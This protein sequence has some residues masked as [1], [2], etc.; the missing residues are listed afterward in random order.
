MFNKK[1]IAL[2]LAV[3]AF[4]NPAHAGIIPNLNPIINGVNTPQAY[5]YTF[6]D[7]G[8]SVSFHAVAGNQYQLTAT[9]SG[10]LNFYGPDTGTSYGGTNSTYTLTANFNSAG[11]FVSTGS[12]LTINGTLSNVPAGVSAP[13]STLLFQAGLTEFGYNQAQA[14]IGF[15]TQLQSGW[16]DQIAFTGGSQFESIYLFDR[17]GLATN[18]QFG[19][20]SQLVDAFANNNPAAGVG[21][22]PYLVESL[23]TVPTPMPAILFGS[24]LSLMLGLNRARQN[25]ANS[26]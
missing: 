6:D 15:Q 12:S 9:G 14:T 24:G 25:K 16:A 17:L 20:L 19:A 26:Q 18:G 10:N 2:P 13:A 7:R 3:I 23:A 8:L 4:S 11:Q 21:T 22:T 1:I 5:D